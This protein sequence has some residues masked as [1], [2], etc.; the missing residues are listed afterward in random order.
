[1]LNA[2]EHASDDIEQCKF[3]YIFMQSYVE[4]S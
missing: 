4:H 1:M 3:L 2:F